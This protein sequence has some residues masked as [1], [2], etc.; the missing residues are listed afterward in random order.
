MKKEEL[1]AALHRI[2]PD[3]ALICRTLDEI[4]TR[5][6]RKERRTSP[7]AFGYRL[8]GAMCAFILMIGIGVSVGKDWVAS[9][10]EDTPQTYQRTAFHL[11]G[12][13][14][15]AAGDAIE[16]NGMAMPMTLQEDIYAENPQ[17]ESANAEATVEELRIKAAGGEQD[18]ALLQGSISGIYVLSREEGENV[19]SIAIGITKVWQGGTKEALRD[20]LRAE[21][22]I[23]NVSV[24]F[25]EEEE[26]WRFIDSMG[27]EFCAVLIFDGEKE[28]LQIAEYK[29]F[30]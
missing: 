10:M 8:V 22:E 25:S 18:Y 5:E 24:S 12:Q 13:E 7:Y 23:V 9:P 30:E 3:E 21:Q 11:A 16:K 2:K 17:S 6:A 27:E 19:C 1:R 28:I 4:H 15:G 26:M 14:D 20:A 29:F